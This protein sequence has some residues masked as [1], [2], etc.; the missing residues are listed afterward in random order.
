M[1]KTYQEIKEERYLSDAILMIPNFLSIFHD[2]LLFDFDACVDLQ[3]LW[4]K[5]CEKLDRKG[6]EP[7]NR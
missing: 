3:I 6:K 1:D 2:R 4:W 5:I 7:L